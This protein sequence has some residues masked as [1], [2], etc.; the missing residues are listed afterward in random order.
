[1]IVGDIAKQTDY[2][3]RRG[4]TLWRIISHSNGGMI[5][6]QRALTTVLIT[7]MI[8]YSRLPTGASLFYVIFTVITSQSLW[9][10]VRLTQVSETRALTER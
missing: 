3:L 8:V 5:L 6:E 1:M 10:L 9:I 2:G 7:N 4:N